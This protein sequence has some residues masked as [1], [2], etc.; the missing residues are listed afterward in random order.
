M[1][2]DVQLPGNHPI[3]R[4]LTEDQIGKPRHCLG[5]TPVTC[6]IIT[7][8]YDMEFARSLSDQVIRTDSNP[9]AH[10]LAASLLAETNQSALII[11]EATYLIDVYGVDG[12]IKGIAC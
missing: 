9:S 7:S 5:I 12:S 6:V 2:D 1:Q 11:G 10:L 3:S 4:R 8:A